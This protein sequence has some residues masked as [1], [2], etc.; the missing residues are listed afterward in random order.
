[1]AAFLGAWFALTVGGGFVVMLPHLR[2]SGLV[3][4]L[5]LPLVSASITSL[6]LGLWTIGDDLPRR[7]E[8][9]LGSL[10][11][12]ELLLVPFGWPVFL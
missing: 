10:F 1:M 6:A 8:W 4:Y 7:W 3:P 5:V 12:S 11:V 2:E 9:A